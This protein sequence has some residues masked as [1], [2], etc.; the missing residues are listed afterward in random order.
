MT[1]GLYFKDLL[2]IQLKR[3]NIYY[4][5]YIKNFISKWNEFLWNHSNSNNILL[6]SNIIY[7][8]IFNYLFFNIRID[9]KLINR[10]I[11]TF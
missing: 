1:F 2:E 4:P 6:L 10:C 9:Y 3:D 5:D 11:S 8:E 7:K